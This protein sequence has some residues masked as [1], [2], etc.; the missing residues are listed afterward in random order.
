MDSW[1][2]SRVEQLAHHLYFALRRFLSPRILEVLAHKDDTTTRSAKCFVR[3]R[4]NDVCVFQWVLQQAC[5]NQTGGVSHVNH[6][7]G[8]H[9]VGDVAHALVVPFAAISRAA[10]DDK[11][12]LMFQ[13]KAFHFVVIN[14]PSFLVE[15]IS[16]GVVQNT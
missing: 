14:A 5:G 12:W 2:H 10:T 15:V 13:R 6:E 11:L 9:L 7:D 4:S 1:E 16:H 3:G 8:T